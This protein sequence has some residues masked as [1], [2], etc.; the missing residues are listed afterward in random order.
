MHRGI[1]LAIALTSLTAHALSV[2]A[3]TQTVQDVRS[4][5]ATK[6]EASTHRFSITYPDHWMLIEQSDDSL[7]I[8]NQP[9][10][11][12]G[13]A[14]PYMIKT[15]AGILPVSLGEALQPDE[16]DEEYTISQYVEEVVVNGRLA[17]RVWN[18]S[19][20]DFRNSVVTYFPLNDRETAYIISFYST[21]NEAAEPAI[22]W[23]HG[24]F[25]LLR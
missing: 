17:V 12:G 23:V 4:S 9:P 5:N 24:S 13:A 7:M 22:L 14:P 19:R 20:G 21:E 2:N 3:A 18:E 16:Y 15:T 10:L 11:P 6:A 1:M 8:Y 25:E